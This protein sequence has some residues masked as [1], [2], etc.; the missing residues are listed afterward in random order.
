MRRR[1]KKDRRKRRQIKYKRRRGRIQGQYE[2]RLVR[3]GKKE[4]RKMTGE[5]TLLFFFSLLLGR[6]SE[7]LLWTNKKYAAEILLVT[8]GQ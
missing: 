3:E 1:R 2:V 6:P 4:M 8:V 5:I 7:A